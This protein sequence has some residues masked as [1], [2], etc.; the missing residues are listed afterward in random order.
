MVGT[1]RCAVRR[2][3]GATS[4]PGS[5]QHLFHR[6]RSRST[7]I[8]H[9]CL[10]CGRRVIGVTGDAFGHDFALRAMTSNAIRFHRHENIG[11]VAALGRAVTN[12]AIKRH[13]RIRIRLMFG[14]IEIGL[15]HP[16]IHKNRFDNSGRGVSSLLDFMTK[17]TAS[18]VGSR[19]RCH[20]PLRFVGIGR[21]KHRSL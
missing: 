5:K 1:G 17:G 13:V 4:L 8:G 20:L 6:Y 15:R 18:E 2:R 3:R 14:V 7:G 16:A 9:G 12:V 19:R 21:E 10:G 11:S